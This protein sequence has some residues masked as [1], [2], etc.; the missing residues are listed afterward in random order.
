[1]CAGYFEQVHTLVYSLSPQ[2]P[3]LPFQAVLGGRHYAIFIYMC[4]QMVHFDPLH[5][6]GPS[7]VPPCSLGD[8][9]TLGST[10]FKVKNITMHSII[11]HISFSLI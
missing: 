5:P 11:S 6:S 10:I 1:M 2:L 3:S 9:T 4:L 7:P 8:P